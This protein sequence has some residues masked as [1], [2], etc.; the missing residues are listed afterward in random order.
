MFPSIENSHSPD[1]CPQCTAGGPLAHG[2]GSVL[3]DTTIDL[4]NNLL[5]INYQSMTEIKF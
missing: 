2:H 5:S 4:K 1:G 3:E